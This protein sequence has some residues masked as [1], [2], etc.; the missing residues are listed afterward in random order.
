MARES[1]FNADDDTRARTSTTEPQLSSSKRNQAFSRNY[2]FFKA[3][4]IYIANCIFVTKKY[5]W[6]PSAFSNDPNGYFR[7]WRL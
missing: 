7:V 6:I 4:S 3:H 2:C 1:C 5:A